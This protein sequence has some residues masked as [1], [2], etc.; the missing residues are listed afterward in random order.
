MLTTDFLLNL[1]VLE[2]QGRLQNGPICLLTPSKFDYIVIFFL[3]RQFSIKHYQNYFS[4]FQVLSLP[5]FLFLFCISLNS[6]L[7]IL[8][9]LLL[10]EWRVPSFFSNLV[11]ALALAASV[12]DYPNC[13]RIV[14]FDSIVVS[15]CIF[16]KCPLAASLCPNLQWVPRDY[17]AKPTDLLWY[18]LTSSQ[19]PNLPLQLY[20]WASLPW[21]LLSCSPR[22]IRVLQLAERLLQIWWPFSLSYWVVFLIFVSDVLVIPEHACLL[23]VVLSIHHLW[24]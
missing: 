23:A 3:T 4:Y 19:G 5:D 22:A 10:Q 9:T 12:L 2:E 7:S 1:S 6:Y 20:L 16:V 11:A 15:R 18:S 14:L 17:R 8:L 21:A 24:S 13:S